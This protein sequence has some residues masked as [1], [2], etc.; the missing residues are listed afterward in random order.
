MHKACASRDSFSTWREDEHKGQLIIL[1][2]YC[3]FCLFCF[4]LPTSLHRLCG[5]E[6]PE[7]KVHLCQEASAVTVLLKIRTH[8]P[9]SCNS[10]FK[11]PHT[12]TVK[13][14]EEKRERGL[15][16]GVG[17]RERKREG[18]EGE[19]RD[20]GGSGKRDREREREG[21]RERR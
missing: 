3:C 13:T 8:K 16:R 18:G 9:L 14:K 19:G 2:Y 10:S 4:S 21:E 15:K 6:D 12:Q 5:T 11:D 17:E 7:I 20:R 1:L